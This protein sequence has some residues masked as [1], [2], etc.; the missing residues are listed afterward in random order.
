MASKETSVKDPCA[1]WGTDQWLALVWFF[2]V[3]TIGVGFVY[4]LANTDNYNFTHN[5]EYFNIADTKKNRIAQAGLRSDS[6]DPRSHA[7]Y[8]DAVNRVTK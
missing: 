6:I 5:G 8:E 3:L 7:T 4:T 1:H 2:G